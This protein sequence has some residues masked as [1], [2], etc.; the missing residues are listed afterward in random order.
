MV[1]TLRDRLGFE[2]ERFLAGAVGSLHEFRNFRLVP[3]AAAR[4]R[5]VAWTVVGAGPGLETIEAA[6]SAHGVEEN[7]RLIGKV[8]D[9]RTALL[10]LDVLLVPGGSEALGTRILEAMALG[11]P[12]VA[13]DD[14]GPA[15]IL[16]PVHAETGASLV[17]PDD[18]GALAELV[19]RLHQD[20][21]LRQRVVASQHRRLSAFSIER[22]GIETLAAYRELAETGE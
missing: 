6:I 8:A 5:G 3:Q 22:T 14:A 10:E 21:D 9:P 1:P 11:V 19:R 4:L 20:A 7:V 18:A 13:A 15:E 16:R 12:V 17:P 2:P